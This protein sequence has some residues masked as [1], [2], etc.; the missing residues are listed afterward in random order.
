LRTVFG[1]C[2]LHIVPCRAFRLH[3]ACLTEWLI[4]ISSLLLLHLDELTLRWLYL[5]LKG[6]ILISPGINWLLPWRD[7]VT[8]DLKFLIKLCTFI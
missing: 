5:Y 1:F 3:I 4:T 2:Q 8:S 7:W 6:A